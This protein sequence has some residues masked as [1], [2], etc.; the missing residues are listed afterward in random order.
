MGCFGARGRICTR[1]GEDLHCSRVIGRLDDNGG[2]RDDDGVLVD[3]LHTLLLD[4]HGSGG[5][6]GL[7]PR[8]FRS[9]ESL[10]TAARGARTLRCL[11]RGG[12][13]ARRGSGHAQLSGFAPRECA[14]GAGLAL[15]CG[16]LKAPARVD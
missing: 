15:V 8:R 4:L 12:E 5:G 13:G 16:L 7:R 3:L 1:E 9:V 2:L 6:N 10:S 11:Q 14:R